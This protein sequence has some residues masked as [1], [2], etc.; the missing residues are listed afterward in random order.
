MLRDEWMISNKGAHWISVSRQTAGH[1]IRHY[2]NGSEWSKRERITCL[3]S[4]IL[5]MTNDLVRVLSR[6]DGVE[7]CDDG[8]PHRLAPIA[9][10]RKCNDFFAHIIIRVSLQCAVGTSTQ[11]ALWRSTN[12]IHNMTSAFR[13]MQINDQ[14][15]CTGMTRMRE[16]R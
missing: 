9:V 5:V 16:L 7:G 6:V 4:T 3:Q 15:P 8:S 2:R 14:S 13:N 10:G 1:V 12:I 11:V